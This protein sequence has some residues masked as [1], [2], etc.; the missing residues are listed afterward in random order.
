MVSFCF[1]YFVAWAPPVTV[2]LSTLFTF[3]KIR[4]VVTYVIFCVPL[5]SLNL[6]SLLLPLPQGDDMLVFDTDGFR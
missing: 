1:S 2:M 5:Y 4:L 3:A 6:A